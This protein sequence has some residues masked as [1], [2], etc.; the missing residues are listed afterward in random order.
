MCCESPGL[1]VPFRDMTGM[2][3]GSH[4]FR[5]ECKTPTRPDFKSAFVRPPRKGSRCPALNP[6]AP[7][8]SFPNAALL[9]SSPVAPCSE[10]RQRIGN[11]SRLKSR[12][13]SPLFS[14]P[15]L[16]HRAVRDRT[17]RIEAMTVTLR[18]SDPRLTLKRKEL[19][20]GLTSLSSS[21]SGLA[22]GCLEIVDSLRCQTSEQP[23]TDTAENRCQLPA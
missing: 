14:A 21:L 13:P 23:I 19:L 3:R 9:S 8:E 6:A 12:Q 17:Q 11:G 1:P 20:A 7:V 16:L 15:R 10:I 5:A 2:H 4:T 22:P 18:A